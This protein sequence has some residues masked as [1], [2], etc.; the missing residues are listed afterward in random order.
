[1]CA[2]ARPMPLEAPVTRAAWSGMAAQPTHS[3]SMGTPYAVALAVLALLVGAAL[4]FPGGESGG[5]APL[6]SPGGEG[7]AAAPGPA[8][9][10][11]PA[12]P[13]PPPAPVAPVSTIARRVERI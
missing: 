4:V 13:P 11:R 5:A 8:R 7:G 2:I 12:R 6:A 1:M 10:T 3:L 9:P